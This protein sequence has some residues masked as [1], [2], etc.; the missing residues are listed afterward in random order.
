[1]IMKSEF[2]RSINGFDLR[3]GNGADY[4]L[5]LRVGAH[6]LPATWESVDVFYLAGGVSERE[7]YKTL[8]LAHRFRVEALAMRPAVIILDKAW[9]SF[10]VLQIWLKK[11]IKLLLGFFLKKSLL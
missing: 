4:H 1:M 8:W 3:M 6:E 2:L 5:L 11:K 10:Q 7:I 9:V